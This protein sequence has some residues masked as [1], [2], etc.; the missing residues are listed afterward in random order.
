MKGTNAVEHVANFQNIFL[1]VR[2]LEILTSARNGAIIH[3]HPVSV[4]FLIDY[5]FLAPYTFS[6]TDSEF[7]ITALGLQYLEFLDSILLKE[8]REKHRLKLIE[9][10]SWV[11]VAISLTAFLLSLIQWIFQI[12]Q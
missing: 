8:S 3:S 5:N 1:S 4:K 7:T 12:M 10:R 9:I 6:K 11:S 2:D